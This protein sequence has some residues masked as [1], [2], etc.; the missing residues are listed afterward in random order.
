M[1]KQFYE[2]ALPTQGV[3]CA[4]GI[5]PTTKRAVNKFAETLDGLFEHVEK[6]KSSNQNVFVALGTFDGFSRKADDCL[7]L[8]SFFIDLD[9][10]EGKEYADKGE[11]HTALYKLVGEAGLPDPTVVDSGGGLHA[12]WIMDEDIPK[13]E[14]K[15]YAERF[16]ALC[17]KHIPIDPSVT[18]DAAR[19]LRAPDTL[20]LKTQ[21]PRPT[22]LMNDEINVYSWNEFREF[23]GESEGEQSLD[24]ILAM[25]PKGLDEETMAIAKTEN[26]ESDFIKIAERSLAGDGCNQIKYILENPTTVTYDEWLSIMSIAKFCND[27]DNMIQLVS[28]DYP[29]YDREAT[30]TKAATLGG[31]HTCEGRFATM[32]PDRCKGCKHR[33]K[34]NTP[35]Q[36]GKSLKIASTHL[37]SKDSEEDSVRA[38]QNTQKVPEF[39]QFLAPFVRGASGGVYYS[40]PPKIDKDGKPH[41]EDPIMVS[42]HDLFP[43]ARLYSHLDGECLQ[44]RLVLPFDGTRDFLLPMKS[45]Y[46]QDRFKEIMSSNGVLF[47]PK[48]VEQLM[49]YIVKWGQ[50]F[51]STEEA[52]QMRQQMGWTTP[53]DD[54]AAFDEGSFV[55]G[56][57]EID[58]T[59]IK[60]V[61]VSPYCRGVAKHLNKRGTFEAWQK[62][63]QALDEVGFEMHAFGMLCGFASPIMGFTS[64][65]GC[66]VSFQ[67]K[68][69]SAKTGALYAALSV[70]GN[71][72][73]LSVFDATDN[74][75]IGRYLALKNIM[76]GVD[77]TSNTHAKSLAQLI[78]RISHGKAKLKMQGSVN[79]EREYEMF[80]SLIGFFTTNQ[81]VYSAL[82]AFK[83]RPDGEAAR[84]VEF[85]IHKPKPLQVDGRRGKQIFDV[86]RLNYGHA[87]EP[88]LSTL[89][90]KWSYER[91]VERTEYWIEKFRSDFGVFNEYRFYENL[92]GA[93]FAA[94]E[95]VNE[96]GMIALDLDR[97]Y[98]VVVREMI[99]IRDKVIKLNHTDYD[100]LLGDF[101]NKY[102]TGV[103][104]INDGKISMEPRTSLVARAEIDHNML[105]VSKPE[106]RKYLAEKQIS[107]R[108]F[109][110]EMKE[111][112]ILKVTKKMRL[113]SGWKEAMSGYNVEVYGFETQIPEEWLHGSDDD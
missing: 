26:Y 39:P 50:Y 44:M 22:S 93:V 98:H 16:K 80:A 60:E 85:L 68:S 32:W 95:I 24:N 12:Y 83:G 17:L 87:S 4:T 9:C 48:G 84:C 13:D 33:G 91:I 72:K 77:E 59:G 110:F 63:A 111:K 107:S 40:P 76:L 66:V 108:E 57:R 89:Y 75:M 97:V 3:Y 19:V 74:A 49:A 81:S 23:L 82:E 67:G 46:A 69:G 53:I 11:A 27:G 34:I 106:F 71:P 6:L 18:A 64:T 103:L 55:V 101:M 94:G 104:A 96:S 42:A 30:I 112:G 14:W 45:V 102:Q 90:A 61:P 73:E 25:I 109:E 2:K 31:P 99:A 29:G 1:L 113:G 51:V 100:T 38:E 70:W 62:S 78:H 15:V 86:F 88:Y 56:N 8:R 52:K 92:V 35:I 41:Y 58:R 28:E 20:N 36:L 21:P 79:A 47:S 54:P 7:F 43:I 5:D 10:G 37:A 65:S 105:F